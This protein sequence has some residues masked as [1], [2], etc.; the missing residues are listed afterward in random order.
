MVIYVL[1]HGDALPADFD[2][3]GRELSPLGTEQALRAGRWL[4]HLRITP[5]VFLVSP[6]RRAQQTADGV[7]ISLRIPERRTT[8]YLT[9]TTDPR[10]TIA[11]LTSVQNSSV[12]L[13]GHEPHLS[14]LVSMLTAGSRKAGIQIKTGTMAAI[15]IDTPIELG[16]GKLLWLTTQEE[17]RLKV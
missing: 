6:L 15:E 5:G 14:T 9:P 17:M 10:N 11:E 13:V 3:T 1:R 7:G 12:L 8:Q 4:K 2:D 16:S